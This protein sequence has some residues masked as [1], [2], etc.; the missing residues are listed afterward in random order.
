MRSLRAI[1]ARCD[2]A[3]AGVRLRGTCEPGN[4]RARDEPGETRSILQGADDSPIRGGRGHGGGSV[5]AVN[6]PKTEVQAELPLSLVAKRQGLMLEWTD[7]AGL[8]RAALEDRSLLGSSAGA[9]I[10]L[11]DRSVSRLHAEITRGPDGHLWVRDHGSTNG[12]WVDDVRVESARI[13]PPHQLRLGG[14][15]LSVASGKPEAVSLWPDERFGSLTAR[16]ATMREL[17]ML[18]SSYAQTDSSVLI[19]GA[20]GTGKELAARTLH[21]AS[22]RAAGP[23][24][25]VDC[26]ALPESL[27][28]SELFGHSKG[29]FTG[30]LGARVG[31]LEAADKGTVFLD[32]I[33]ELPLAMQ[34]KLLRVLEAK[35]IR[36][37][38]EAEHRPI[39]VRFVAATHRDLRKMVADGAFREDLYFRLAVLPAFLPPLRD[40]PEDI[41]L[42]LAGFLAGHAVNVPQDI[43]AALAGRP[44]T[45]N[46]RELRSFA[47]RVLA[48][49]PEKAWQITRAG[50]DLESPPP[51]LAGPT[52]EG[53]VAVTLDVPFKVLREQWTDR[54]E[55]EYLALLIARHGRKDVPALAQ[56]A[57][58]D[59]S[60]VHRLLRKHGL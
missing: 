38:G 23:F 15:T 4:A 47:D 18:L 58:L 19:Q 40:R 53:G 3:F 20:T 60:Y 1:E 7:E 57:G 37:V 45:G 59:R 5:N 12:T 16:S 10:T 8:S 24:I 29:A 48:V 2:G 21:E 51:A 22:R 26:G 14:T 31:A 43:A 9:T 56:V 25:V 17:F 32:E 6:E 27:L 11:R 54:L 49:G 36:R 35:T 13:G 28:E 52:T 42:L 41:P 46:V 34:P 55:R 39:D 44:W 33:G 30:A 50:D